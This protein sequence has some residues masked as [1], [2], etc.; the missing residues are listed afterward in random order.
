MLVEAQSGQLCLTTPG[1]GWLGEAQ[2]TADNVL[3]TLKQIPCWHPCVPWSVL[4]VTEAAAS[5]Q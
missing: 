1:P 3:S 2:A 5:P 4:P